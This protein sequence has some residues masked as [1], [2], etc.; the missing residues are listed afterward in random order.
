MSS[1]AEKIAGEWFEFVTHGGNPILLNMR[2]CQGV[3][4]AVDSKPLPWNGGY[5]GP[6]CNVF[7][8]EQ[9]AETVRYDFARLSRR[10]L[11]GRQS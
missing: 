3:R 7:M 4:P 11:E 5:A 2:F 8:G 6:L 9:W 10:I 1:E